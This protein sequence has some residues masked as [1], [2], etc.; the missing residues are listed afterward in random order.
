VKD[1]CEKREEEFLI[2]NSIRQVHSRIDKE[3]KALQEK[4]FGEV[5]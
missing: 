2:G 1:E 3:V 4:I 5:K